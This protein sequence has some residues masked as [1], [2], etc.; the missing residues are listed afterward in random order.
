MPVSSY[1]VRCHQDQ[2]PALRRTL[3]GWQGLSIG[4]EAPGGF[5]LVAETTSLEATTQMEQ[6]LRSLPGVLDLPV[7]YHHFEDLFAEV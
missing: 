5:V 4:P 1:I 3:A 6:R 2:R 7:V